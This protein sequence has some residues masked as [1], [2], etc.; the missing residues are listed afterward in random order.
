MQRDM[1]LIRKILFYV[2][3]HYVAGEPEIISTLE[4]KYCNSIQRLTF[5][6]KCGTILVDKNKYAIFI[7]F[8]KVD[9]I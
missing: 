2:E 8:Q 4:S 9:W 5:Q 6:K 1:D 7:Q 3:E